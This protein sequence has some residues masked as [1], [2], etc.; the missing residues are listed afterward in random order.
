MTKEEAASIGFEIAA[1][2]GEARSKFLDA[3]EACRLGDFDRARLLESE[4]KKCILDAH[5]AHTD[6]LHREASGEE[7]S[8]ST[9]LIHGQD[10]LMTSLLLEDLMK[11]IIFLYEQRGKK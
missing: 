5:K 7:I 6:L 4:A 1:Y 11:H 2:A 8:F 9:T 3:L 10:H